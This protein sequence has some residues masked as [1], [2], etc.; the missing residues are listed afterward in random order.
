MINRRKTNFITYIWEPALQRQDTQR[1]SGNWGSDAFLRYREVSRG[2]GLQRGRRRFTGGWEK[3]RFGKQ[4]FALRTSLIWKAISEKVC[5]LP[6]SPD[7]VLSSRCWWIFGRDYFYNEKM[8]LP[9]LYRGLLHSW[10]QQYSVPKI[11][12]S[13]HLHFLP[14]KTFCFS[15][16]NNYLF[17]HFFGFL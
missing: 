10:C 3:Q 1:R 13:L 15:S 7:Q 2:L 14:W 8:F 5:F 17:L 12:C 9:F 4:V 16:I 11:T 6:V